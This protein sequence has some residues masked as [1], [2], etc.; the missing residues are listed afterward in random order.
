MLWHKEVYLRADNRDV[1]SEN[2]VTI[3]G[4]VARLPA[5]LREGGALRKP[6]GDA[7]DSGAQNGVDIKRDRIFCRHPFTVGDNGDISR[8]PLLVIDN[9]HTSPPESRD[10]GID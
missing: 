2:I 1:N 7:V 5:G 3:D 9:S 4:N 10:V 6:N 8:D